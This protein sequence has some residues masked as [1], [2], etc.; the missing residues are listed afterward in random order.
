MKLAPPLQLTEKQANAYALLETSAQAVCKSMG[1]DN[2]KG[3]QETPHRFARAY[4]ELLSGHF[5]DPLD[6]IKM[7]EEVESTSMVIMVGIPF[8][9]LCE[10]HLLPFHGVAHV[11][12]LPCPKQKKVIG[13][14]KLARIFHCFAKQIQIQERIGE[15][16]V[17]FFT[18]HEQKVPNEGAI[19]IIKA[20]HL[21]ISSRGV[22]VN[23]SLVTSAI[24]GA[25]AEP[26]VRSEFLD[27][28]RI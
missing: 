16:F 9:S 24:R 21:C 19:C 5:E 3:T 4:L 28:V 22:R 25:F 7:F 26:E 15:Q 13:A 10:H 14:S 11:G 20:S 27:L 6:Y 12:Y 17:D 1:K 18:Q 2:E 8:V 23:S